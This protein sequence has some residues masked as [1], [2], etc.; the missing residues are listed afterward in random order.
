ML[1]DRQAA[2]TLP[3]QRLLRHH[4]YF[5]MSVPGIRMKKRDLH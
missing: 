3:Q 1:N 5:F 4:R 2:N